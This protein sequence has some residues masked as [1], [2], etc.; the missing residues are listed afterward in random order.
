MERIYLY[1]GSWVEDHNFVLRWG[2]V[3]WR[4]LEKA[5]T[6]NN[7]VHGYV[8]LHVHLYKF[9]HYW[10]P[11]CYTFASDAMIFQILMMTL[12]WDGKQVSSLFSPSPHLYVHSRYHYLP[13]Q[14]PLLW[15][16]LVLKSRKLETPLKIEIVIYN[17]SETVK[18]TC[19]V[20]HYKYVIMKFPFKTAA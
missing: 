9:I 17:I 3:R 11:F 13:C 7:V 15:K 10:L 18:I 19:K 2:E 20:I 6:I 4:N 5:W 16:S 1:P 8:H 12:K 14:N